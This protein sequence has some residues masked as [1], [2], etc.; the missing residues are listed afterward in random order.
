MRPLTPKKL[1]PLGANLLGIGLTELGYRSQT[2]LIPGYQSCTD[3]NKNSLKNAQLKHLYVFPSS[4][5]NH[6]NTLPSPI[7]TIQM[8]YKSK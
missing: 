4:N 8:I 3:T 1:A 7:N 2:H 5:H 6:P